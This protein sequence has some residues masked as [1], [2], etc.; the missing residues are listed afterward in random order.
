[1]MYNI[2]IHKIT[3]LGGLGMKHLGTA[4]LE[5]E[6]LILRPFKESDDID[7]YNNWASNDAVTKYLT[8]PTHGS[9]EI[10]QRVLAS[11]MNDYSDISNYQWCIE[12]KEN[13]Q[14]IGS[15]G[16]VHLEEDIDAVEIGYCIGEEYWNKGIT[17]EAFERVIKFL[18]EEVGCNRISARHDANNPNSGKVMKKVGLQYEGTLKEAGRNNTGICNMEVYGM[19][20][21]MYSR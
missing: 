3:A 14:A 19:T 1:M 13:H 8:W 6:R 5:T 17:S 9:L 7:M 15:F 21:A 4:L 12:Y 16:V 20:K 11:W 2:L 18:F 10:S